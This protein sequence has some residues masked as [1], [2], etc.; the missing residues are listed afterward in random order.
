MCRLQ[1]LFG[2][3][4]QHLSHLRNEYEIALL[5]AVQEFSKSHN[6]ADLGVLQN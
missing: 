2:Y 6:A 4:S 1:V 3:V 5:T